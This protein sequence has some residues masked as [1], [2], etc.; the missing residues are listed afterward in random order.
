M[1]FIKGIDK[2]VAHFIITHHCVLRPQSLT[3]KLRVVFDAIAKTSSGVASNIEQD[4]IATLLTFRL[5]RYALSD[6]IS[7]LYW[8]LWSTRGTENFT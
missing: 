1:S 8:Q 5:H 6:D 7:K 4:L 3:T 2:G